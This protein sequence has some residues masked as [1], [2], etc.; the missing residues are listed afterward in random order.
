M[1]KKIN[2]N[3]FF[4]GALDKERMLFD[5]LIP[6]P[7]GTTYNSYIIKGSEK[8]ALMDTV[9]PTKVNDLI[10]NLKELKIKNIDYIITHH[11]EQDHSGSIPKMLELF[12]KAVVVTNEKCKTLL[13]D[14]LHISEDKF[15][16]IDDGDRISLGN[17][18][19]EFIF[20]PWVHWPETFLTYLKEDKILFS[21]DLFGS[22]LAFDELMTKGDTNVYNSAKRYYAEIMMPFSKH[23]IKHLERISI[24]DIELIAPSHGPVYE[25]PNFI[26][27][28]YKD[29]T[30]DIVKNKVMIIYVSMH[31][32]TKKMVDYLAK[33]I[34]KKNIGV[35]VFNLVKAD[36]GEIAMTLVD[37][38]TLVVAS[39]TVLG[40]AHPFVVSTSYV[41]N[42]LKPKTKYLSIIG[43]SGWSGKP[44]ER[45][46]E[47]LC[48][49][50]AELLPFVFIKGMPNEEDYIKLNQLAEEIENKH[51]ELYAKKLLS[52]VN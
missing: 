18:T 52:G 46:S 17:K 16:I 26:I 50:K 30:S 33:S 36:L 41:I 47:T 51:N 8:T 11:A 45:F 24:Y 19:L 1:N 23:V 42:A 12:P 6:T 22:H 38:A 4:V 21:C 9:D 39:P 43:S 25:K 49:V 29:W 31:G 28:A 10:N 3:I 37:Y 48:H 14:L 2:E 44:L 20:A 32:S 27:D 15:K 40:G 13:I 5:E 35:T 7:D 34:Q